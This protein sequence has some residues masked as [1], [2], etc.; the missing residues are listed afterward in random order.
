MATRSLIWRTFGSRLPAARTGADRSASNRRAIGRPRRRPADDRWRRDRDTRQAYGRARMHAT[1]HASR[2]GIEPRPRPYP[3]TGNEVQLAFVFPG[4]GSQSVGMGRALADASP[5]AAAVFAA[6]DA[7]LGEPDQRLAWDGPAEQLD[8]TENAQPALLGDVDRDPGRAPRAVGRGRPRRAD[9]GLRGRPLDGPVLRAR[10]GRA[11]STLDDGV[12]LVR[13]RGRLMQA[14]G[15]GRDGAMA[16]LIGLDDARLPEL[17]AGAAAHGVFVVANRN[18]PGPGRRVGRTRGDRGRRRARQVARR[19]ARHRP[20]GV[21]RGPLAADGRGGR[22]HARRPGRHRVPRSR[23]RP[24]WPTPTAAPITTAD[25]CRDRARRAPDRRRRLD[26]RRRADGRGRRH[27]VRRSRSGQGP[28][29]PHQ[30]NRPGRR[31]RSPPTTPPPPIACSPSAVACPPATEPEEEPD[32]RKPDYDRRVVVT[33]LG[34]ISPVGNDVATAWSNLVNGRV[35]PRA[36]SPS[37]TRRR[38]RPSSPARSTTSRHPTGWTPRPPAGAS[39]ACTS[40]S[41]RPSRRSPIR[42]SS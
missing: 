33:G 31:G 13:E 38:T 26:P 6:A 34:V 30:A 36:R 7:A 16:A 3:L 1:V 41:R 32:V 10:R 20:A 11:R 23:I 42:A 28:D 18:A 27:D 37:S 35:R 39:R 9:P 15:Q 5:A 24:S 17:V 14:S 29:R 22:R 40:G 8:L 2:R 19:E 4:Q 25:G 21:G 12:R